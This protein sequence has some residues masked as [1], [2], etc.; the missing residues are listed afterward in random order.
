MGDPKQAIYGFRGSN[1][2]LVN[3]FSANFPEDEKDEA[4]FTGFKKDETGLSSEI[5]GCSYRSHPTLVDLSNK[6]F[7]KAFGSD[8]EE[9]NIRLEPGREAY[10]TG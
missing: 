3:E 4:S 1:V 5:L 8:L 10:E 2:E 7:I 6:V 9:K